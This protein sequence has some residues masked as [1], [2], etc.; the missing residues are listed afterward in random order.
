MILFIHVIKNNT[1]KFNMDVYIKAQLTISVSAVIPHFTILLFLYSDF[2]CTSDTFG[3]S[4]IIFIF[5]CLFNCTFTDD[6]LMT[7]L[8][9]LNIWSKKN[10]NVCNFY[11]QFLLIWQTSGGRDRCL[12]SNRKSAAVVTG[13]NRSRLW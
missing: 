13:A 3:C 4:L 10:L 8:I 7:Q 2:T 11:K 1:F 12:L 6:L 9:I 5:N